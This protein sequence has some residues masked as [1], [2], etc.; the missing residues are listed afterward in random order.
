MPEYVVNPKSQEKFYKQ[1]ELII[2]GKKKIYCL[3]GWIG[4]HSSIDKKE[5]TNN[6]NR[7]IKNQYYNP[8]QIRV[9]VRGKLF[10]DSIL[11]T[12]PIVG[13]FVN[14][15]EGEVSFE[16]LDENDLDDI[17]TSNRQDFSI[18]DDRVK[19][20]KDLLAGICRQLLS[21]RQRLA[22]EINEL[23]DSEN[24]KIQAR[25]KTTFSRDVYHELMTDGS[26]TEEKA[27]EWAMVISNKLKGEYDLKSSF[28]LFLS[29]AGKDRIF[30]DFISAYLQRIGFVFD[31]EDISKTE[32]FYSSDGLNIDNLDPLSDIIKKMLIED[33]TQILFLTSQNF[34]HSQYCLFEGGAVWAHRAIGEYG[35]I[36][37][38]YDSI[39]KFLTNGKSEFTFNMAD[40][41]SFVLNRQSYENIVKILNKAIEHLNKNREINKRATVPLIPAVVFKDKVQAKAEGKTERDYMNQEVLE[42]WKTYVEEKIDEYLEKNS[43]QS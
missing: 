38:D 26:F 7:Y 36:S 40:R 21:D 2:D 10:N 41:N 22:D 28:K 35:I 39:P 5:A 6:D 33:N 9:Y 34:L 3:T 23:I 17:A 24:K 37:L 8:N 16:I 43:Q 1:G 20:L 12:L 13:A 19:L 31:K 29:H 42:Y 15:I 27:N 4:I 18:I 11:S 14:Y 30:T 25:E 32:I